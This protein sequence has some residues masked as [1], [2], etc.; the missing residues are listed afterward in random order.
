MARARGNDFEKAF[1]DLERIVQRLEGEQLSLDESLKLFEQGITLSRFCHQK[2]EEV[3]KKI[4]LILSDAK[5]NPT[6]RPFPLGDDDA[7]EDS[8]DEDDD[9]RDEFR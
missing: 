1:Q 2:L 7:E 5:G 9:E 3:E 8:P 4:E 6:S